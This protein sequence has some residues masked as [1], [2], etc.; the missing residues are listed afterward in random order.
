MSAAIT[1]NVLLIILALAFVLLYW[2]LLFVGH[3]Y[4]L[5][6]C[7]A[8]YCCTMR[9]WHLHFVADLRNADI[10]DNPGNIAGW[11][12]LMFSVTEENLDA[13][14]LGRTIA[15]ENRHI[16]QLVFGGL[17]FAGLYHESSRFREWAERSCECAEQRPIMCRT[18]KRL[19]I[20]SPTV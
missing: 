20:Q 10:P 11:A 6:Q 8:R 3:V 12:G 7:K 9:P 15:H 17:I 4:A 5:I 1:L 16:F 19:M 18:R 2:G 13:E 14:E